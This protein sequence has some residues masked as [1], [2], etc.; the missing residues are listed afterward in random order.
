[1][2]SAVR[3]RRQ[4]HIEQVGIAVPSE[5]RWR[6]LERALG[7]V[8][9]GLG[10]Y[11]PER[12]M[13]YLEPEF[14]LVAAVA[15][16]QRNGLEWTMTSREEHTPVVDAERVRMLAGRFSE[17][18]G[19]Q[20]ALAGFDTDHVPFE[21]TD[22]RLAEVLHDDPPQVGEHAAVRAVYLAREF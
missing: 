5:Q 7:L 20:A 8:A 4:V 3:Y 22:E 10:D 6:D 2:S 21:P 14:N 15:W 19:T 16:A 18:V 9:Y 1:M 11:R 13:H 12:A 17:R